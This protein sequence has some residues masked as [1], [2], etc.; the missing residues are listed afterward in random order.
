MAATTNRLEAGGIRLSY[1]VRGD[2]ALEV[3]NIAEL[4]V[5][6]GSAVGFT[7]P[8]GAGKTTL[9]YCLTGIEP[10]DTG[11]VRWG[12]VEL[13]GLPESAR[14]RWRRH[15]VGFV[16]QE[17]HLFEGLSPLQN[18][19]LPLTFERISPTTAQKERARTLLAES[20]VP[21]ERRDV[22][23]MSRGERQ[24]VAIAR[25]LLH[26]PEILVVDE[27][28]ASLDARS[29]EAV[30]DLLL[31]QCRSHRATLLAVTHDPAM[32]RRLDV[33]HRLVGGRLVAPTEHAA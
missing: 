24:R 30:I 11:F 7:G 25:A 2:E 28:T 26:R 19:L 33:V 27:P 12:P 22:A 5:E 20:G 21:D 32:I 10:P 13:T 16:F 4:E 18:V 9:L 29:G 3:L 15:R 1:S 23:L 6:A 17:F 14:D 31:H 8:S